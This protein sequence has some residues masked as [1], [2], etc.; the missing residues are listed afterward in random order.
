VVLKRVLVLLKTY[1]EGQV[2]R[3]EPTKQTAAMAAV[4]YSCPYD[5]TL[6]WGSLPIGKGKTIRHRDLFDQ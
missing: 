1:N 4:G 2:Q 6:T 5:L 3:G